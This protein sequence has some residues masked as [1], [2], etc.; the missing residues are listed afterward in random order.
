[1]NAAFFDPVVAAHEK[2]L[3]VPL[4]GVY[5]ICACEGVVQEI[6]L[7]QAVEVLAEG[8]GLGEAERVVGMTGGLQVKLEPVTAVLHPPEL[9]EC[10]HQPYACPGTTV[11]R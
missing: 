7:V 4:G 6:L 5:Q 11:P 1:M 10:T 3:G 8:Q 2:S 9:T